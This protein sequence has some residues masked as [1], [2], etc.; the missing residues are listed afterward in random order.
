MNKKKILYSLL[1]VT[2]VVVALSILSSSSFA[3][4]N[5]AN[6]EL[7]QEFFPQRIYSI[8]IPLEYEF[9]GEII[10]LRRHDLRERF[11]R[12]LMAFTYMHSTTLLLI[13]RANLYFPLIEPVL[14]ANNVP[15][16]F[17]YLAVIESHLNPRAVSPANAVGIWQF[18]ADTA[19][20]LGL[21][22][23][24]QVDE[25]LHL[26]KS[27]A[28]AARFLR[29]SYEIYGDWMTA[30]ASYNAG[31]RRISEALRAQGQDNIF[32]IFVNDETS[33]YVF[34]LLAVKEVMSN[35]AKYGFHLQKEDF[36][37]TVRTRE[38]EV[39]GSI[40]NWAEWARGHGISYVQ[41]RYFNP[42]IRRGMRL[43]N[44]ARKTYRVQ[45]PYL[46][47]LYFDPEKIIIHN[48]AWV[49]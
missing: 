42:W 5:N 1:L 30:A 3:E 7:M 16:D 40:E 47:D 36:Y 9:A 39:S 48:P 18:L 4:R 34:R 31:R 35:P 13:K 10:D 25:R 12:E 21:E 41:L 33:R 24:D 44:R 26:E 2:I 29:R 38:V 27:T 28:A 17:R 19:R 8:S 15:I 32:D 6:Q 20:E 49:N 23:T 45:I 46:E 22:V 37:H 14:K 43:D 11:D